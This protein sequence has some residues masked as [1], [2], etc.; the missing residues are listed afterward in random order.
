MSQLQ[1]DIGDRHRVERVSFAPSELKR[2]IT[3]AYDD[4][5]D[6][7]N[8]GL[9][10]HHENQEQGGECSVRVYLESEDARKVPMASYRPGIWINVK[11]FVPLTIDDIIVC[12]TCGDAGRVE[13][14]KWVRAKSR[15]N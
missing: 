4:V 3:P 14:S 8:F 12:P 11:S 1:V 7:E 9:I 5:P 6:V 13:E 15:S 10:I 2:Q